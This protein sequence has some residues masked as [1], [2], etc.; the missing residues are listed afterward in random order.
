MPL[1]DT[2]LAR[3]DTAES[4]KQLGKDESRG[5]IGVNGPD[6]LMKRLKE[7]KIMESDVENH[8]SEHCNRQSP[9]AQ[10]RDNAIHR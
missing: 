3:I 5:Q 7:R 1:A 4:E 6:R 10:K 2:E 9:I 8:A